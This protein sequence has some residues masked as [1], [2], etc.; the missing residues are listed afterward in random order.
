MARPA[1]G[2]INT[3]ELADGLRAFHLRFRVVG[4]RERVVLHEIPGCA[5]GCGGGWDEPAARTELGNILARVR[6]GVWERPKPPGTLSQDQVTYEVPTFGE[7]AAWWLQAKINGVLGSKPISENTIS[8]YQWRLNV[9]LL[10]FF[11]H[12]RLDEIDRALCL[13]FKA[14][15][16]READEQRKAIAA[17]ADLRDHRGRR[18]VPL[19]PASIRKLTSGLASILDDAVEDEHVDHHPARGKRMRVHV[20]KPNRTFLEMDELA[21][22]L[23]AA[24]KQDRTL[25]LAAMPRE[26]GPT[27]SLVAH[28]LAQGKRPAQIAKDLGIAKSTVTHHLRR[29]GA[30]IGRGYV[31]R[32]VVCEIL[33]RSG[34]RVGELCDIRIGQVRL[35]DRDGARFRIPDSNTATGIREVQMSPDLVEA[36]IEHIDQLRRAGRSTTP[37]DRLVQNLNGGRMSRQRAAKIVS[38]AAHQATDE[39]TAKGLPPLPRVTPHSLRRTYISIAL[40]ANNFDVK[41]VMGQVGHADSK[42]TLDVYAQLEQRV[43]RSHGTSFDRLVNKAREHV[44]A[45]PL[46]A[47]MEGF[48]PRMGHEGE[49][50]SKTVTKRPR[51]EKSKSAGL[52]HDRGMARL[53][54]EPRTPRFSVVCS[55][56]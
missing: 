4:K 13:E 38:E 8:D 41:W 36:V 22:V 34:V 27:T 39:L 55:T 14:R 37:Q 30:N 47:E 19:G 26:I 20:P 21:C 56:N 35:H 33:G 17:G 25:D 10:P 48:G 53:G 12:Y 1:K 40:L 3:I 46:A 23:D 2:T 16:L 18:V 50:P 24:A 45:L 52:Q 11:G 9:H 7:Y 42:M 28:L 15:K 54:I 29:A 51:R 49:K 32:R 6:V 5:C 44:A 31:G 43:D